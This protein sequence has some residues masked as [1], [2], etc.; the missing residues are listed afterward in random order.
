MYKYEQLASS[1]ISESRKGGDS[2]KT[3]NRERKLTIIFGNQTLIYR[4]LIKP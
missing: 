2:E 3:E 4:E 1:Q